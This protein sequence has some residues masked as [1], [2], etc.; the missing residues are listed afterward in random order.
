MKIQLQT[1]VIDKI[2]FTGDN[3]G[4]N[5][6]SASDGRVIRSTVSGEESS[7]DEDEYWFDSADPKR[8]QIQ[9]QHAKQVPAAHQRR[10]FHKLAPQVKTFQISFFLI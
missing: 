5:D 9:P 7:S 1:N 8:P 3:S 6:I 10:I 4:P 2:L